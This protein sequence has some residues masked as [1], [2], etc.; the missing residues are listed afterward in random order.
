MFSPEML[1]HDFPIFTVKPGGHD[2]EELHGV[3]G[4]RLMAFD[5]LRMLRAQDL[6][7]AK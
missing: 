7:I 5:E 4:R 6:G 2:L 1:V 3:G